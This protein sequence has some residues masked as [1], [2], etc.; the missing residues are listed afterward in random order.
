MTSLTARWHRSINEIPEQ[1]WNSL[2]GDAAIP[3]YRWSWLEALESSGSIIPEQG[4]QP[5]HLALWR[6]DIPIAVAPLFLKG[7]SYG[8]FVFD[9]T[10]AR[11]AADLGLR[12]YPCLLY[13]SPSP[14][15]AT[16]SRMPSSA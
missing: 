12:Y 10:F 16:L 5:L 15:D 8:E 9:Q 13:T 4:W 2:V 7:H 11:L 1:Q 14:R 3:F 6:D